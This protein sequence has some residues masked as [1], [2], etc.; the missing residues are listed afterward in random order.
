MAGD[1]LTAKDDSWDVT[2]AAPAG[3]SFVDLW[4][5]DSPGARLT[6]GS[7]GSFH[8]TLPAPALGEHTVIFGANGADPGFASRTLHV[9]HAL[10]TVVST[11]WDDSDN[12]DMNYTLMDQLRT[13][14]PQ[15]VMTQ[16]FGPYVITDMN[17]AAARRASNIA[18]IKKQHDMFGDEIG[19]HIHPWCSFV[20]ATPVTCRT[21][22]STTMPM[23]DSSG[24]TV[25]FAS[26]TTDEQV[27]LLQSA[28]QLFS[29][30]GLGRPTSFRAGG[31]TA[32]ITTIDACNRAGYTV[33]SSAF[34][35]Y[36][37]NGFWPAT[38]LLVTWTA[39]HWSAITQTSQPYYPSMMDVQHPMPSPDYPVLE[40]PDNGTLVDYMSTQDMLNVLHMIWP[41]GKAIMAPTVFQVGFHPPSF[42]QSYF[43]RLDG[44]LAEVDKHLTKDDGGPMRYARLADLKQVMIWSAPQ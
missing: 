19:V 41:D 38:S 6:A 2:V 1:G 40:V 4:L 16:F 33:E 36:T 23:G 35:P 9:S 32:D 25:L 29:D 7:D 37:L 11:D 43:M 5:D 22:P 26:Y 8:T 39:Q 42:F 18:Y 12:T 14:H 21:M 28:A 27:Q 24:Y 17:V 13:N 31:W 44:A 30:N 34:P 20:S 15:L 10:Y 3:T